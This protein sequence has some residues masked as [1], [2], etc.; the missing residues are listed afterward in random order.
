MSK[1]DFFPARP[2]VNPTVYAYE[3]LGVTTHEGLLKIGFTDRDAQTRISE[4]LKTARLQYK[5]VWE[6]SA[7][8]HDGSSFTDFEIHRYLKNK[9]IKNVEGEWFQCKIK[10]LN[11]A[12]LAI[13]D[14]ITNEDNRIFSFSMRPEQQAAVNK[15]ISYFN[16]FKNENTDK[17]PHFLW[18][19][20]MRFGKTF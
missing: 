20:K 18:N 10:D 15:T 4:Q 11:A 19:A 12:F 5:I 6:E 3:L 14:R 8:R 9:G 1:K 7:M 17:T 2:S 13:R 16:S